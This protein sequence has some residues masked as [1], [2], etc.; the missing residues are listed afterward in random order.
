MLSTESPQ[1]PACKH[2]LHI[3]QLNI[4]VPDSSCCNPS[5]PSSAFHLLTLP[6][7]L[8]SVSSL[9][10]HCCSCKTSV[11]QAASFPSLHSKVTF[12]CSSV[13]RLAPHPSLHYLVALEGAQEFFQLMF[14]LLQWLSVAGISNFKDIPNKFYTPTRSFTS[15]PLWIG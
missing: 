11:F 2:H 1:H 5:T 9:L 15:K 4:F 10:C 8:I 14:L 12:T 13:C 7:Y 6:S 3:P